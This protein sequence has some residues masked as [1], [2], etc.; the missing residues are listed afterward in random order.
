M[1]GWEGTGDPRRFWIGMLFNSYLFV[2]LF[3]PATMILHRT[4]CRLG[5]LQAAIW[6]LGLMSLVFYAAW[7]FEYIWLLL[8]SIAFNFLAGHWI[9][10]QE[11]GRRRLSTALAVAVNLAI[12]V[13]FKYTDFLVASARDIGLTSMTPLGVL[14][15]IGVSF[16]TFTQIA[17]IVDCGRGRSERYPFSDYLLFVTFFPHLVAGPIL[18]HQAVI[19]QFRRRAFLGFNS[20]RT[21]FGL[22]FFSLGVFKKVIVADSL[23]PWVGTL[24]GRAHELNF[25]EAW[26]A[27]LLYTFQLYFDF[28]GYSEMAYGLALLLNVRIPVNFNSPYKSRSIIEFWRRWHMSLSA[29]LRNYLYVPLGGNRKGEARRMVNIMFTMLLGG[30]WHGAGWTFAIWGGLHGAYIVINHLWRR[31]GIV[32]PSPAAWLITFVTVVV[33]WVFFRAASLGDATAILTTMTGLKSGPHG[34]AVGPGAVIASSETIA[35][36]LSSVIGLTLW[37][38]FAPNVRQVIVCA[39]RRYT[40]CLFAALLF[41]IAFLNMSRYSEFLYFQF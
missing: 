31:T 4:L 25:T 14:L 20:K 37:C 30:L 33:G 2:V 29:F 8:F 11:G 28:S 6:W 5:A 41:L 12:L 21:Y 34:L 7:R 22:L 9:L 1:R 27:A 19:P 39:W 17:Y 36:L 32:L 13:Y 26:L 15:P 35:A 40:F 23:S 24:F 3:L 10:R 18:Q 38:V 16:F